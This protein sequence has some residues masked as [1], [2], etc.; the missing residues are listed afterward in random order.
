MNE[1]ANESENPRVNEPKNLAPMIPMSVLENPRARVVTDT[2][3]MP[4]MITGRRPIMS[5][6]RDI[7]FATLKQ[8]S[9][10]LPITRKS[11]PLIDG[12]QLGYGKRALL[13]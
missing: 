5:S 10:R 3:K 9:Q 12:K 7:S 6:V 11:R 2:P 8:G 13:Q 4:A 1:K